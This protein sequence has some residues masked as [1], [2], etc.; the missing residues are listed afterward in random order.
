MSTRKAT[1]KPA[2]KPAKKA[3]KKQAGESSGM[4]MAGPMHWNE[5]Q[6]SD[7]SAAKA[8]YTKL[9]GWTT[10]PFGMGMDYTILVNEGKGFAGIMQT[11]KPGMPSMWLPYVVVKD[12]DATIAKLIRL[13]GKVCAPPVDI[14]VGRIA[15]VQDPQ[16]AT[17]GLHKVAM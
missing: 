8:F 4:G 6:T 7:A 10:A 9:F 1:R 5:L 17:F 16:G 13:G 11:P 2:R 14:S 3:A 12:V 15:V